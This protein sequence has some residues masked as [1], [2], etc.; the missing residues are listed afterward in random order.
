MKHTEWVSIN[1]GGQANVARKASAQASK[2]MRAVCVRSRHQATKSGRHHEENL[3]LAELQHI[4][5]ATQGT[6]DKFMT[7]TAP[8]TKEAALQ[9]QRHVHAA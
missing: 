3:T 7:R 6:L 4:G 9:F 8:V 2:V 5:R 1:T